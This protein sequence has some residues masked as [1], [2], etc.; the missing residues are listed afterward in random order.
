VI[1]EDVEQAGAFLARA[2][3]RA[4]DQPDLPPLQQLGRPAE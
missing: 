2:V 1:S 4:I 3:M